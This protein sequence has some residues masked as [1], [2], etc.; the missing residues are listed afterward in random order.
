MRSFPFIVTTLLALP[1]AAVALDALEPGAKV[2]ESTIR[3]PAIIGRNAVIEHAYIGPFTSIGDGVVL[4]TGGLDPGVVGGRGKGCG[5]S[6]HCSR[7][8]G[9]GGQRRPETTAGRDRGGPVVPGRQ[10]DG[11][12]FLTSAYRGA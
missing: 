3:G 8:E 10:R 9:G 12:P 1:G 2:A 7:Q 5:C 6:E 11:S 4:R